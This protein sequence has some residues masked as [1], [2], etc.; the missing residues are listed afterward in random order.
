MPTTSLA[1][2]LGFE[3]WF[4]R[5]FAAV[6]GAVPLTLLGWDAVSG[7]LPANGVN[8][9]I[10]TTGLL[11]LLFL[12]LSLVITPLRRLTGWSNL[13]ASRR[14]LGLLGFGYICVHFAI[15]FWFDRN[16]SVSSTLEE[17]IERR[18]L[19]FGV[20]ALLL[21]LPLA[22]TSTDGWVTRLGAKRW[23]ALHRLAYLA[24]IAGATHY[25]LLVKSDVTQPLQ[26]AAALGVLLGVR[27]A[28]HYFD[29][30]RAL[31]AAK[32]R[33]TLT[34]PR[35]AKFWSG[36][37]RIA[38]IFEETH[39]VRTFRMVPVDGGELPF[40]QL[41]GQYLNLALSIGGVATRRSYT[42][43]SAPTRSGYVEITVKRKTDGWGSQHLHDAW[44]ESDRVKVSAPAGTFHFSGAEGDRVLLIAGGVGVTPLM[45]IARTLTDRAWPGQIYFIFAVRTSRDV[46]FR[47]ELL[48]LAKRFPN[49]HLCLT[50][51]AA[52]TG[53]EAWIGERGRID[54]ALLARHVPGL[55]TMPVFLCGP[56]PMMAATRALL[57]GLG[58]PDTAIHTEAF[59]SPASA[60]A[61]DGGVT[62]G[63]GGDL[64]SEMPTDDAPPGESVSVHFQNS[65]KDLPAEPGQSV[66]EAAEAGG[67]EL[68]YECR[69]GICGQCKVKLIQGRV[70]MDAE[71]ALTAA[72]RAGGII[73][74]CQ[75]HPRTDLTI[76]A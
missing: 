64:A 36:E 14:S 1:A 75:A 21:M 46:I 3:A 18:Y 66:L 26:F 63:A 9:A 67:L 76:D 37:L 13:I 69:S 41:P 42:I 28:W 68:P 50:L 4:I 25:Y 11:G 51:S 6:L 39:D 29:L 59:L 12:L 24:T 19:N 22:V 20:G 71:D 72:D 45:A 15:F 40:Q 55:P 52:G 54:A 74:A 58:V 7:A 57:I 30:R 62:A 43:A 49:F 2:R 44:H 17:I 47:D 16:A 65:G 34:A 31:A 27:V 8:F 60:A 33:S 73:L 32:S 48:Y 23:K 38:R 56:E 10:R 61:G 53:G 5:V 35:R 70:V